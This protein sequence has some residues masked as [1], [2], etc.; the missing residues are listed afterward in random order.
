MKQ[1]ELGRKI[2]EL[3]K[4]K[5]LTQE[6]LV[7]RCNISVRTIQRIEAGEVTPRS[8]TVKTIMAALECDMRLI[9]DKK[10][11]SIESLISWVK[12][13]LLLD[14]DEN[15]PAEFLTKQLNLAWIFG[16]L[17]FILGFFEAAA[18]YFR[19]ESEEMIFGVTG[20]VIIKLSV[21]ITFV[22]FQR[23]FILIGGLYKNYLLKIISV[24]WIFGISMLLVYDVATVFYDAIEQK[25]VLGA[26]A[27]TFGAIGIVYGF[28]LARLEPA[29]G[30]IAKWAGIFEAIAG[31]FF[32]TIVLFF[33]GHIL[34]IPAELLE[35]IILFK[36]IEIVKLKQTEYN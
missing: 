25:F 17:Y 1:P 26:A 33:I 15:K 5:G 31:C 16:I 6:E 32:I 14:I 2:S 7:E 34:L 10:Q 4:A 35:I 18:D 29:I 13:A 36:V 19:S 21:L 3:R 9:A 27:V 22:I 23:G 24:I 12:Q 30:I 11:N 8:Y 28:S 20:Y